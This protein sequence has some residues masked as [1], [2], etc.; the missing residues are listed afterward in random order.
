MGMNAIN[1]R[2]LDNVGVDSNKELT[3]YNELVQ[4]TSQKLGSMKMSQG[5][6]DI[7]SILA[8][9]PNSTPDDVVAMYNKAYGYGNGNKTPEFIKRFQSALK[10]IPNYSS[11]KLSTADL[12]NLM[13]I[14]N[15]TGAGTS[16]SSMAT[17]QLTNIFV[18]KAQDYINNKNKPQKNTII[19]NFNL[20]EDFKLIGTEYEA[21]LNQS[22]ILVSPNNNS[23]SHIDKTI[24]IFNQGN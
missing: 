1:I 17:A 11:T 13:D 6:R 4:G 15:S 19:Q 3:H 5:G 21:K 20:K 16:G 7:C 2:I 24:D 14:Y 22:K 8:K 12:N 9:D 10:Q 23:T 18:N